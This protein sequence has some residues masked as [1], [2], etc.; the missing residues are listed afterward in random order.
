[1]GQQFKLYKPRSSQELEWFWNR[2]CRVCARDWVECKIRRLAEALAVTHKRYPEEWIRPIDGRPRCTAFVR[3]GADITAYV[4]PLR[5]VFKTRRW[6]WNKAAHLWADTEP[7]LRVFAERLDLPR[8]WEHRS[9]SGLLHY[10]LTE[11]KR[12]EALE[13]GAVPVGRKAEAQANRQA[14]KSSTGRGDP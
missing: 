3:E 9:N 14:R 12:K 5:T 2:Y 11:S 8:S 10:D 7:E 6:R 1:M 4:G 13:A